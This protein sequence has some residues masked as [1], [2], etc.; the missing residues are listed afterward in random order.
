VTFGIGEEFDEHTAAV[1]AAGCKTGDPVFITCFIQDL[2]K[3]PVHLESFP[4]LRLIPLPTAALRSYLMPLCR[5]KIL[6]GG[7]VVFDSGDA[8]GVTNRPK[9]LKAYRRVCNAAHNQSVNGAG[10]TFKPSLR[11]NFAGIPMREK[12]KVVLFQPPET[13]PGHAGAPLKLCQ[14]YFFEAVLIS[15]LSFHLFK[16]LG[17][18]LNLLL[19]IQVLHSTSFPWAVYG[20]SIPL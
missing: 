8:T 6:V 13:L 7:N 17:N 11:G 15:R 9:P 10:K 3:A 19:V 16:S 20:S 1:V 5:D 18:P 4:R 2:Y 12:F 14:V